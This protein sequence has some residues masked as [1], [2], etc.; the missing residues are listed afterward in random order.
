MNKIYT[1]LIIGA[2]NIGAFYDTPKSKNILTHAHAFSCRKGFKLLGFVDSNYKKANKAA[3]IWG[4]AVFKNI[5]EAFE[6]NEVDVVCI[7]V[8]D[9]HH[10]SILR[11]VA[12]YKPKIVFTEKPLAV[13]IAEAKTIYKLYKSNNIPVLLNYSRRFVKE[14]ADLK[15]NIKRN[16]YGRYLSGTG[17]YGKGLIHNGSH[18]LDFIKFL[19]EDVAAGPVV[20]TCYDFTQEDP[21]ISAIMYI[22]NKNPFFLQHIDCRAYTV[23]EVDLWFEKKRIRI[24]NSGLFVEEFD[25]KKS[26]LFKGYLNLV[27]TKT[28]KTALNQAL[29]N[30][31]NNIYGHLANNKDLLCSMDDGIAVI[32]IA[33]EFKKKYE[34]NLIIF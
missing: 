27:N 28:K 32:E 9:K 20:K 30:S 34:K 3:K 23:F 16:I 29:A 14:L 19:F 18:M 10:F 26:K 5:E 25:V 2:G 22:G 15:E 17:Y 21:S 31:L 4:G 1:V 8:P 7:A 24:I 33:E 6:K 13:N 12:N 11:Q